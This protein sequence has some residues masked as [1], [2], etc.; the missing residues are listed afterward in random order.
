MD[1]RTSVLRLGLEGSMRR[2]PAGQSRASTLPKGGGTDS[3]G[4]C[5]AP[6]LSFDLVSVSD[7]AY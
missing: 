1:K 3:I 6:A 7:E 2:F 5:V 4:D